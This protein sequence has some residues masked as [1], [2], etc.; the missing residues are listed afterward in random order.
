MIT[1]KPVLY[2]CNV[3][4]DDMMSGNLKMNML[5]KLKNMQKQKIQK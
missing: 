5:K 2:A 1:S 4:E 3:S